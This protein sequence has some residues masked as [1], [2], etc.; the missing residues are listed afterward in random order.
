MSKTQTRP[1][2][3][4]GRHS[5]SARVCSHWS[6][7]TGGLGTY[8][9]S[10]GCQNHILSVPTRR[11]SVTA[12]STDCILE[13]QS[14]S[15]GA[16]IDRHGNNHSVFHLPQRLQKPTLLRQTFHHPSPGPPGGDP[17]GLLVTGS[18]KMGRQVELSHS[19]LLNHLSHHISHLLSHRE[20]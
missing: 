20:F 2:A 8:P 1:T 12:L 6:I 4:I 5:K 16:I 15:R 11:P 10:H 18:G 7:P 13:G 3:A 19:V 14:T 9:L 17:Q